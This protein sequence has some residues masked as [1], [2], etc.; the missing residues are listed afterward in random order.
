MWGPHL[1]PPLQEG[2]ILWKPALGLAA[3]FPGGGFTAFPDGAGRAD[4]QREAW[5][6]AMLPWLQLPSTRVVEP[7]PLPAGVGM[8]GLQRRPC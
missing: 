2:L 5:L 6:A 8:V 1:I 3:L 4:P 7:A